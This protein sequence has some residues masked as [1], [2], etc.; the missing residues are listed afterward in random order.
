[1]ARPGS[2]ALLA[3]SFSLAM[4]TLALPAAHAA[5]VAATSRVIAVTVFPSGAEVVR[6]SKV[7]LGQGDHTVTFNDLP[8]QALPGSIRVEGK[9]SGRLE[10]G[11]VDTR[12]VR[13]Q[14]ADSAALAAERKQIEDEIERTRDQRNVLQAQI[15][16][17][18]TQKALI[19]NLTKLPE[20]P[21][22]S[23]GPAARQDDWAGVLSL[24]GSG[25]ADVNKTILETQLRLREIDRKIDDLNR[26]LAALAPAP[27][28]RTEVKVFVAAGAALE[29]D[30]TVIYQV[31]SASWQSIYDAR[32]AT[33][34]KSTAPKLTLTRRAAIQQRTG[35]PWENVRL[36]L[37]TTR[38]T[39]GSAAPD[40]YPVTVDFE[41]NRPPP[42][43]APMAPMSRSAAP[44]AGA[45]A[46]AEGRRDRLEKAKEE[47]VAVQEQAASL[48]QAPFQAVFS[49]SGLLTVP[50]TGETKR[51]FVQEETL[52]PTLVVQTVPKLAT[53][54]YLYAKLAMPR[55]GAPY[56]PGAVSLF[57][58]G[59]FVGTGRLPQLSPGQ[60]H[61]LGFGI[62][63]LVTVKYAVAEEKRGESG[64]ISTSRTDQRNYR[65]AVKNQHER[66]VQLSVRDQIPASLNQ[67]IKVELI[68]KSA[69]T[70]KDID[71]KRG[72]L[73]WESEI[74]PDEER[75]I[76]FGYRIT[77]PAQKQ[78]VYGR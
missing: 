57:R 32:L 40:L 51:V 18:Q 16:A 31:A 47:T 26:K 21:A 67:D 17:A 70:R 22:A 59:T 63:D 77:W 66:A 15:E 11:S 69:P 41:E 49:T 56:L 71:D 35:E 10:I 64:I 34:T 6:G 74:K 19:A 52:D 54:A 30:L 12:R 23:N 20:R 76:E 68:G 25:M 1:M 38:P 42:R 50:N 5:D 24:I 44:V 73:A 58:D 2:P 13:L 43:P 39:A 33:G 3:L 60:D 46:D 61:E 53:K 36:A 28:E 8:A 9:S 78:V 65:I 72:V 37:S 62:D 7:A 14:R 4:S 55:T 75:V 48:E 27:E 29:A 45:V